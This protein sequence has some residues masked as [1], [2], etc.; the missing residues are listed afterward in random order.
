MADYE[1][2]HVYVDGVVDAIGKIIAKDE[3][4]ITVQTHSTITKEES[5]RVW[6]PLSR[7]EKV[8]FKK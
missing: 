7:V 1:Q 3:H 5:D 8:V 4:S 2:A 6:Y